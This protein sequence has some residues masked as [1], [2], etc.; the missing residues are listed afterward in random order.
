MTPP[1]SSCCTAGTPLADAW[2]TTAYA[3]PKGWRDLGNSVATK[4]S[5]LLSIPTSFGVTQM[6]LTT[7]SAPTACQLE[8]LH[9]GL[10]APPAPTVVTVTTELASANPAKSTL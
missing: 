1:L 2:L 10:P 5:H 4:A 6:T 8:G 3:L 7:S 9:T